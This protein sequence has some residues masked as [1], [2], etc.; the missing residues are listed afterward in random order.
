M[1]EFLSQ[2]S[3]VSLITSFWRFVRSARHVRRSNQDVVGHE[4]F[5]RVLGVALARSLNPAHLDLESIEVVDTSERESTESDSSFDEVP[6]TAIFHRATAASNSAS[7]CDAP[8]DPFV[9]V[10]EVCVST[11]FACSRPGRASYVVRRTRV[12]HIAP[13]TDFF[14]CQ[15]HSPDS[16]TPSHFPIHVSAGPR[17]FCIGRS[18]GSRVPFAPRPDDVA[19]STPEHSI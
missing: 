19:V 3:P 13:G 17:I 12:S 10:L 11:D 15:R 8:I 6:P 14:V 5:A 1:P 16:S 18:T 9:F 2:R 4:P 7:Q